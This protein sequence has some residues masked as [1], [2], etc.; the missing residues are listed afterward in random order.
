M[1]FLVDAQ[2]PPALAR[3]LSKEGHDAEHVGD[4]GLV[5]ASDDV[6]WQR[7]EATGATI[8]T[9][10]ED[11]ARRKIVSRDGPAVVWIRIPNTRRGELLSWFARVLP[12]LLRA[13]E[14]GETLVEVVRGSTT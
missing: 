12:D 11:F 4:C 13:L 7:A 9:K 10:D 1:R 3:Q 8:I 14:Q 2:L 6:I 5:A